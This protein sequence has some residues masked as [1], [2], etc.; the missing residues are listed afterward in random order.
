MGFSELVSGKQTI[1]IVCNQWGDSGKGKFVHLFS[2]WADI[3]ARGT[4]GPNAG[5]TVVINDKTYI[6]HTIPSGI[7]YDCA[8]KTNVMGPGMVIDL[9]GLGEEL[10]TLDKER[11]SYNHLVISNAANVILPQHKI[12]DGAAFASMAKGSVGSTGRGIGPCYADATARTGITLADLFDKDILA[13]KLRENLKNY[14]DLVDK[15]DVDEIIEEQLKHFE[16]IRPF[17]RETHYLMNES[18]AAGKKI[19][20]EGAQGLLLSIMF[21]TTRYQTSSD[22]SIIG[23]A[24]GVGL[25]PAVVDLTL[26][27]VKAPYMTRVGNGP[28]P[29]EF[30]G[31]LAEEYCADVSHNKKVELANYNLEALLRSPREF[32]QGLYARIKGNEYG[33]TT[34]RPRRTGWIDLVAL[35]YAAMINKSA[36]AKRADVIITKPDVM[37]EFDKIK[38]C[39]GYTLGGVITTRF[40]HRSELLEQCAPIY[41]T[42]DGWKTPISDFRDYNEIKRKAPNLANILFF[43]EEYAGV[44]IRSVSVGADNDQTI[45][46]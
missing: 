38:L 22:C 27:I 17:V 46:R 33:A 11:A 41:V 34:G 30:G 18:L 40:P 19:L 10:D 21:G 16:R 4:G 2:E 36:K 28:F 39:V 15:L 44:N 9:K 43:I 26:G 25:N 1:A 37:D 45:F 14:P 23:T 31:V 5:H 8:G 24:Q 12:R 3:I 42:M 35:R 6:F 7:L 29:T 13:K 32:D 20:L